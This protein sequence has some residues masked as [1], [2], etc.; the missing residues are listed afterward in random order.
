MTVMVVISLTPTVAPDAVLAR[1]VLLSASLG[2]LISVAAHGLRG[3]I[4]HS[5]ES[6]RLRDRLRELAVMEDG[7]RI[8]TD[9]RDTVIQR[10]FAAGLTLQGAATRTTDGDARR[11]IEAS[12]ADLDQVVRLP[13]DSV[14]GLDYHPQGRGLRGEILGLR[15][16]FSLAPEVSFNGPVDGTLPPSSKAQLLAMLR[17]ALGLIGQ[18]FAPG[19]IGITAGEESFITVI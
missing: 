7:D 11:G 16:E 18:R 1:Q 6:A 2:A 14:F 4:R 17:E 3:R 9:L 15:G 12:V 5:E 19:Q 10:V 8:A 13:R